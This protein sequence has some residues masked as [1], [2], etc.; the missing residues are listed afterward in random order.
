LTEKNLFQILNIQTKFSYFR[1]SVPMEPD[2]E[3]NKQQWLYV[4]KLQ[5]GRF[6]IGTTGN[7]EKRI[8]D[9]FEGRGSDWTKDY[10]PE[11]VLVRTI[12]NTKELAIDAET[13]M[14]AL[15]I[16]KYGI[17]YVRGGPFVSPFYYGEKDV[18]LLSSIIGH[19]LDDNMKKV[20]DHLINDRT[21]YYCERC[22]RLGHINSQCHAKRTVN[23]QWL[24]NAR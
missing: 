8:N 24:I 12:Y 18:S 20:E 21:L 13:R 17:N 19:C 11:R 16:L 15:Y 22:G 6:Y 2:K 1:I 9:H 10:P 14:T 3:N 23:G 7:L 5:G 4:L